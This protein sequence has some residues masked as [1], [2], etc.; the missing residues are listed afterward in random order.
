MKKTGV[1]ALSGLFSFLRMIMSKFLDALK[2]GW[3]QCPKRAFL[4]STVLLLSILE[5]IISVSMP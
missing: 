2:K 3:C 4:I 5:R 1:N